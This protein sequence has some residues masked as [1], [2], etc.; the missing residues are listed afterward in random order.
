[1]PER[2]V[3]TLNAFEGTV[4]N[5]GTTDPDNIDVTI[6]VD[7]AGTTIFSGASTT[8]SNVAT[9]DSA[10]FSIAGAFTPLGQ[11]TYGIT[12]TA[13]AASGNE[14]DP[15]DGTAVYNYTVTDSVMARDDGVTTA[16]YRFNAQ[17]YAGALFTMPVDGYLKAVEVELA[18]IPTQVGDTI[19][20]IVAPANGGVPDNNLAITGPPQLVQA[21]QSTYYLPLTV[22][23]PV[24]PN[25]TWLIGIYKND[26]IAIAAS[27]F[28]Y[29]QGF[30]FFSGATVSWIPSGVA[31]TRFIRPIIA[32]CSIFG[33]DLTS[34]PDNGS[35]NGTVSAN[36]FNS[37][38]LTFYLWDDPGNSTTQS[39]TG[40]AAGTY[41]VTVGDANGCST[42]DTVVVGSNVSIDDQLQA[43]ISQLEV[44]P[45]PSQGKVQLKLDLVKKAAVQLR[46]L[47]LSGR[48]VLQQELSPAFSHQASLNLSSL[49]PGVYSLKVQTPTGSAVKQVVVK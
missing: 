8:V 18:D 43:G 35:S 39:V 11:A 42:T 9:Y 30:N 12:A 15:S 40:L 10:S 5:Q 20:A 21:G 48:E 41:Q 46:L 33:V 1:M 25:S 29:E 24:Q 45:N 22:N 36:I 44:F 23:F 2:F 47:D 7:S 37:S 14:E 28:N 3:T 34:T 31:N 19:Y 17:G 32:S 13:E 16:T 6:S 4:F 38:G 49:S 27:S 26:S